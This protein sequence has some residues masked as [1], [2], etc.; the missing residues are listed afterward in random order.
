MALTPHVVHLDDKGFGWQGHL[1]NVTGLLDGKHLFLLE[2]EE[3]E[4]GGEGGTIFR[5]REEF[6]GVLYTPLMSWLGMGS[7]TKDGFEVF[8]EALKKRAEEV[9]GKQLS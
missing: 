6:G 5:H 8:G 9:A 3:E 4:E 1:A 2:E 7:R